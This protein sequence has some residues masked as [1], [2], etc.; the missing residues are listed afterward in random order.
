M[1]C[2]AAGSQAL[3]IL[4]RGATPHNLGRRYNVLGWMDATHLLVD[5]DSKT[6]AVLT[7]PPAAPSPS[8]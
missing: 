7:P 2:N 8:R 3:T 4:A 5:I 6:L 1:A